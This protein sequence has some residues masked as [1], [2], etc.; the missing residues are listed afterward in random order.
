[1]K[2]T[3]LKNLLVFNTRE[4]NGIMVLLFFV[5]IV[6]SV[7]A[8]LPFVVPKHPL[9]VETF[10]IEQEPEPEPE[11][12]DQKPETR[13]QRP[14]TYRPYWNEN[15][16]SNENWNANE[17]KNERYVKKAVFTGVIELN[18]ADTV[19]LRQLKGVGAYFARKIID[20]RNK[21]GGYMNVDQVAEIYNFPPELFASIKPQL[22]ANAALIKRLPINSVNDSIL[23]VHPYISGKEARILTSYRGKHGRFSS[24]ADFQ[25]VVAISSS[26]IERLCPYLTFE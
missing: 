20:Y 9:K 6:G 14:E 25:K 2:L 4:K 18:T 10:V 1:M 19:S 17:N 21:L 11:T 15:G 23:D 13:N 5:L 22:S 16:N 8:L 26:T 24:C 12:R 3:K 7:N